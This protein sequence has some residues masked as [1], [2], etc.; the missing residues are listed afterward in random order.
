MLGRIVAALA[1]VAGLLL[2]WLMVAVIAGVAM[3]NLGMQ[4]FA[5]LFLSTEYGLLYITMLGAP[6]ARAAARP[7]SLSSSSPPRS[8]LRRGGV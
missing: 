4:P 8:P 2:V 7:M 5:W 6:L 1:I 3:R